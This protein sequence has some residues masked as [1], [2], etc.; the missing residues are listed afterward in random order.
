MSQLLK[1]HQQ[2]TS[3]LITPLVPKLLLVQLYGTQQF[4]AAYAQ[5]YANQM[6]STCRLVHSGGPYGENLAWSSNS[7]FTGTEGVK[8][9]VAE[10]QYYIYNT[11][12]CASGEV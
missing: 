4:V 7:S 10:K 1:I 8:L 12:S 11:R 9:W 6:A 3:M 5:N 2:T